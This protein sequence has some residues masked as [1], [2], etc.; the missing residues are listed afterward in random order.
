M[1][2]ELEAT[3]VEVLYEEVRLKDPVAAEKIHINNKVRLVRVLEVMRT[4][5]KPFSQVAGK[6]ECEYDVEWVT[7]KLN[8]REELYKR[9]NNRV[10]LMLKNGLVEETEYLLKKHGRIKNFVKTIGYAE[11]LDYLDGKC[12]LEDSL[13]MIKQNTRRY[14]K[15][16]LTWFRRNPEL[17]DL[18]PRL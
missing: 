9:V 14:A 13:E 17:L 2:A 1:R 4:F 12:A 8:S 16:Q 11:I 7:P 6:K 3:P 15:R 18:L 5:N 10:D